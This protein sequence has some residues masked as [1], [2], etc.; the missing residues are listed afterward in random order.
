MRTP[1]ID[2]IAEERNRQITEEGFTPEHDDSHDLGALAAASVCY[3]SIATLQASNSTIGVNYPP[4]AAWPWDEKWWKP[5][6]D[7]V[8]NLAKAGALAAAEIDRYN[9]MEEAS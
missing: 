2:I 9:R 4:P 6:D 8:V 7:P 3:M 5:S 1:G